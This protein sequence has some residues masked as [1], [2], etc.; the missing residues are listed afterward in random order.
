MVRASPRGAS[1]DGRVVE[2]PFGAHPAV[3]DAEEDPGFEALRSSPVRHAVEI[4]R[5]GLG[6]DQIEIDGLL[7]GLP[8]P[9]V[10]TE[11]LE[12]DGQR[13]PG[14]HER[15]NRE[16]ADPAVAHAPVDT[17]HVSGKRREPGFFRGSA[18]AG[19]DPGAL[20]PSTSTDA[21]RRRSAAGGGTND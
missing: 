15:H 13:L 11:V 17:G 16:E 2:N 12:P 4:E 18:E 21:G 14:L 9:Q 7:L 10:G 8:A 5:A 6:P 20:E 3:P 19:P 1:A